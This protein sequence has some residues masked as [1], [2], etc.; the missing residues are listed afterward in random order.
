MLIPKTIVYVPILIA[1]YVGTIYLSEKHLLNQLDE[2]KKELW[3]T[4]VDGHRKVEPNLIV[5]KDGRG[6]WEFTNGSAKS[7]KIKN[8]RRKGYVS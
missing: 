6:G 2:G 5:G 3:C 7:C 4:F 8:V 1:I